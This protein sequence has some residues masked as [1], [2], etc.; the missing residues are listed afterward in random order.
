MIKFFNFH[1]PM[2]SL[3]DF[4]VRDPCCVHTKKEGFRNAI[5]R[6][7]RVSEEGRSK[8]DPFFFNFYVLP[9]WYTYGARI[10]LKCCVGQGS[11]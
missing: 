9:C 7:K 2:S 1:A 11:Y 6:R 3:G 8:E 5:R 10:L 4:S